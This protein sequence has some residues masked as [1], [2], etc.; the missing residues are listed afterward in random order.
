MVSPFV[1]LY[2]RGL[3]APTH[4]HP[5]GKTEGQVDFFEGAERAETMWPKYLVLINHWLVY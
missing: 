5:A 2:G 1:P 3:G 4:V